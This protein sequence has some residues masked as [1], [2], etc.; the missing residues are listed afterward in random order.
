MIKWLL[1]FLFLPTLA[2]AQ[3]QRNPCY[4]TPTNVP[5][6]GPGG[7]GCVNVGTNAPM[8]VTPAASAFGNGATPFHLIAANSN[9]STLVKAGAGTVYAA[10]L[11]NINAAPG[12]LKLYDKATA[13]TCGTD[14]PVKT[15]MIPA[16][17][18]AANGAINNPSVDVGM[19]FLLGIGICVVTGIADSDN[20]SVTAANYVL[21]IDFK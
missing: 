17:A 20:T 11:A 1:L 9:N 16:A 14:I 6:S 18:T 8:P 19:Q 5:G 21:N 3:T 7:S 13:P 10:Q 15:F 12:Y 2:F 4:Y